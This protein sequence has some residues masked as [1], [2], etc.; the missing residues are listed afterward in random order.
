MGSDGEGEEYWGYKRGKKKEALTIITIRES[1]NSPS[2]LLQ[3][4]MRHGEVAR[5]SSDQ[6]AAMTAKTRG[7]IKV[8]DTKAATQTRLSIAQIPRFQLPANKRTHVDAAA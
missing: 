7:R 4:S 8:K 2:W 3:P 5:W 6:L 1:H